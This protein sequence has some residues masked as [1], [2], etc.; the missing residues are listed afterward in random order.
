ME[1]STAMRSVRCTPERLTQ[2]LHRCDI[3]YERDYFLL[4]WAG[5]DRI[6]AGDFGGQLLHICDSGR[7]AHAEAL[8]EAVQRCW[9]SKVSRYDAAYVSLLSYFSVAVGA[10]EMQRMGKSRDYANIR[11]ITITSDALEHDDWNLDQRGLRAAGVLEQ[12]L[13]VKHALLSNEG[14]AGTLDRFYADENAT[15]YIRAYRYHTR[16][17]QAVELKEDKRWQ[18]HRRSDGSICIRWL[19][20]ELP[21]GTAEA[22]YLQE[23]KVN[24]Q[25]YLLDTLCDLSAGDSLVLPLGC[26][27]AWMNN[28][29]ELK[30]VMQIS[31]QDSI[32]GP[33]YKEIN[34]AC[35]EKVRSELFGVWSK[36]VLRGAVAL[37]VLYLLLRLVIIPWRRL[38]VIYVAGR[39]FV[40]RR[41]FARRWR[42]RR[43]L[44]V[45]EVDVAGQVR[46]ARVGDW[47]RVR[48]GRGPN[49]HP[50]EVLQDS[51]FPMSHSLLLVSR[52]PLKLQTIADMGR[53]MPIANVSELEVPSGIFMESVSSKI[54][55]EQH[56]VGKARCYPAWVEWIYGKTLPARL[57]GSQGR[58]LNQLGGVLAA[59]APKHYTCVMVGK[60]E[61]E[62]LVVSYP[63]LRMS[64][65]IEFLQHNE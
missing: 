36:W 52:H 60:G 49:I 32:Y 25:I 27:D 18:I 46:S 39:K 55:I 65:F 44:L 28:L 22:C 10:R 48:V 43:P 8:S 31:Y 19:E 29:F 51:Y 5:V 30:G 34:F 47:R 3:D 38:C 6:G 63:K 12:A 59:I 53:R 61:M 62:R 15:P 56:Y 26:C 4:M 13:K 35:Q 23:L 24:R 54:D 64:G 50:D 17:S 16:Q 11:V 45:G 20:K 58:W 2:A 9:N 1:H 21:Y 37:I 57:R 33:H 42:Q 41:S 40:V 7:F 14:G